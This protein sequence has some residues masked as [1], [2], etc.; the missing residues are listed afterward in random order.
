MLTPSKKKR[1]CNDLG[2]R[3]KIPKILFIKV[4]IEND[5]TYQKNTPHKKLVI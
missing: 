2:I 4:T 3:S 5:K 1:L